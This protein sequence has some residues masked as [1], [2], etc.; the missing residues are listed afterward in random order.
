MDTF[1]INKNYKILWQH[2][3]ITGKHITNLN[4]ESKSA[5]CVY[6]DGM[7]Q[8]RAVSLYNDM[9]KKGGSEGTC[10]VAEIMAHHGWFN[11]F[12]FVQ[13]QV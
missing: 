1:V 13:T 3:G 11:Q 9:K 10:D 4:W 12:F 6:V 7:I 5:G 8:E 2:H